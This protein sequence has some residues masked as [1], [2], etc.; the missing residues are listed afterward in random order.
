V[1]QNEVFALVFLPS[2]FLPLFRRLGGGWHTEQQFLKS[3]EEPLFI[4]NVEASRIIAIA[5]KGKE[6]PAFLSNHF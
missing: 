4:D 5:R 1:P 2:V 6:N 3:G